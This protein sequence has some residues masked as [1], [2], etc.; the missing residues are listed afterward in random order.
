MEPSITMH[1]RNQ[2]FPVLSASWGH[3]G[4]FL[5]LLAFALTVGMAVAL[6]QLFPVPFSL[7][8]AVVAGGLLGSPLLGIGI[9]YDSSMAESEA[10]RL[11]GAGS[12]L[13]LLAFIGGAAG[14]R[15]VLLMTAPLGVLLQAIYPGRQLQG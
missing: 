13:L 3:P 1:E 8:D 12:A 14:I 2:R 10:R 6:P 15:L 5:G 9:G 4:L 7:Q 11:F